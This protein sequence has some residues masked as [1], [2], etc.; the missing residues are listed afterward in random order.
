MSN[1]LHK[2]YYEYSA[3][4]IQDYIFRT[5]KLKL[6]IGASTL[7]EQLADSIRRLPAEWGVEES[8]FEVLT[9]AAG[10]VRILFGKLEDAQ[11]LAQWVP[12]YINAIAPGLEFAQAVV[13]ITDSLAGA[14]KQAGQKIQHARQRP[15]INYPEAGPLIRRARRSGLPLFLHEKNTDEYWSHEEAAKR[16]VTG[17]ANDAAWDRMAPAKGPLERPFDFDDL[18]IGENSYI[19]IIHAD[20]NG[21]G[22]RIKRLAETGKL[23]EPSMW[24]D[25]S[26]AIQASTEEA[27]R[28]SA[29]LVFK[30]SERDKSRR[31][32]PI[33]PL[34]CAGDDLTVI[35]DAVFALGF[36]RE[37]LRRFEEQSQTRLGAL[38][39][40]GLTACAGIVFMK[41]GFPFSSAYH[42]CE[43][44][45][46]QAKKQLRREASGVCWHRLT[47][48]VA[49][50]YSE[51]EQRELTT[52][53]G[54][55][56]TM[57][58]YRVGSSGTGPHLGDLERLIQ[59]S[60]LLPR[61]SQREWVSLAGASSHQADRAFQRMRE[62]ATARPDK[63]AAF[64]AFKQALERITGH[65]ELW[66]KETLPRTPLYDALELRAVKTETLTQEKS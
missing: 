54:R 36:V 1:I 16:E 53:D 5:D 48:G 43:D 66:T 3:K 65:P 24:R 22:E 13:P 45:C 14:G 39:E 63:D 61:S 17:E 7:V 8:E 10:G 55:L 50:E 38:G 12:L 18:V 60:T 19:A 27:A 23:D 52:A 51:I 57:M 11:A 59:S 41:A 28:S 62:I 40:E 2:A 35:M 6:M 37:Y 44:L 26:S 56:L 64:H 21:L 20:A 30:A 47:A 58:P 33:R 42:L 32:Y 46:K 25:F 9:C 15:P 31:Y 4:S 49:D 34:V 29:Q